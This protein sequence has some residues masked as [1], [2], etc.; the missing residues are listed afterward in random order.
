MKQI[1]FLTAVIVGFIIISCEKYDGHGPHGEDG[2]PPGLA[3]VDTVINK[4]GGAVIYYM[5]PT[6][7]DVLY[8]K[9]VFEDSNNNPR[10]VKS[11]AVNDSLVIEG[12]GKI[13]EYPVTIFAVDRVENHS[14][15]VQT[16]IAPLEP[17]VQKIF[18]TLSGEVDYGGVKVSYENVLEAEVSINI[19]KY[20]TA[21]DEMVYRQS[22]FTSQKEGDYS[23]RGFESERS[24]FGIYVEDRWGNLSDTLIVELVPRPDEFLDKSKF[25]VFKLPG[26]KDFNQYGFNAEQMWDGRWSDQWNCGHTVF[27]PLPHALTIDLGVNAKLSRFKLYQR[28]GT[29]LYKHGNPKH[30]LIYGTPDIN[31]LPAFDPGDPTAGWTLLKECFS[32]KPSGLPIG[33]TTAED[34][35]YQDKGE[36]F[37]FDMENSPEIR[38]IRIVNLETWGQQQV[39][40]I[41]ELSFWGDIISGVY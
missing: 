2:T 11:S 17:P 12:L 16:V 20:D 23:F 5:P 37:E 34:V 27:E 24:K 13:G 18:P 26:D 15:P 21:R 33:Q 35:E 30:F 14:E 32:F 7:Q 8:V 22:F 3:I 29:E 31:S 1:L 10:E 36:D 38:Y 9:A 28:G 41:G 6:D 40:V 25:S 19:A 4:P 39:T